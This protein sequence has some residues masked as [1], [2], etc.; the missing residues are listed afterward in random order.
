[1]GAQSTVRRSFSRA[2]GKAGRLIPLAG[3]LLLAALVAIPSS[4]IPLAQTPPSGEL[5]LVNADREFVER[6]GGGEFVARP[7]FDHHETHRRP[8][9]DQSPLGSAGIARPLPELACPRDGHQPRLPVHAG[10]RGTRPFGAHPP[11]DAEGPGGR[12]L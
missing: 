11:A 10:Q 12:G 5:T 6:K 1:M 9:Q 2:G 3:A 4:G 7:L 8:A